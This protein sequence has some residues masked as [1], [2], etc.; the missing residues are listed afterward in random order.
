MKKTNIRIKNQFII[1]ENNMPP[2]E[3]YMQEVL[4]EDTIPEIEDIN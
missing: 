4:L 2:L 3:N 1:E